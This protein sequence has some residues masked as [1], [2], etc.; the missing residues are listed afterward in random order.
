MLI[1]ESHSFLRALL[2][3]WLETV[4]PGYGVTEAA[5]A[6]EALNVVQINPPRVLI[7]S[8]G[9]QPRHS[10]EIT[11][12]IK[13]RAP[14]TQVVVLTTYAEEICQAEAIAAGASCLPM[15][16]LSP[17]DFQATLA[18]L[19]SHQHDPGGGEPEKK[20]SYSPENRG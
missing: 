13:A 9:F 11:R 16:T 8:S 10:L 4:L 18:L 12:Q 15:L 2:R 6:E 1:L 7:M 5:S 20:R 17:T 19:L 3:R 14:L